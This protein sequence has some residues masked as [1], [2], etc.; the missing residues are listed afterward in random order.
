MVGDGVFFRLVGPVPVV[1]RK[2][3][4]FK[5]DEGLDSVW[6]KGRSLCVT[7]ENSPE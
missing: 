2:M 3:E 4:V 6:L 1:C 7:A 5:V